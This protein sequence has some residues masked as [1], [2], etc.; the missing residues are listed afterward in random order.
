MLIIYNN[1]GREEPG[2]SV[3]KL[4]QYQNGFDMHSYGNDSPPFPPWLP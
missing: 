3:V 2:G 1:A 4:K